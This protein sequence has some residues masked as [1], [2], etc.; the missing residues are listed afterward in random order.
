[1]PDAPELIL[2]RALAQLLDD[3]GLA[4]YQATGALPA[5]G[6]KTRPPMPTGLDEFTYLSSQPTTADG[7]RGNALYR[8]QFF[9]YRFGDA[10]SWGSE[11]F[12]RLDQ[13][14]YLPN[15]L[16]IS[17]TWETSRLHFDPDT[18]GR[19]AVACNYAFR[20]RRP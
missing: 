14:E 12:A 18:H 10:E 7:G 11:L 19:A 3:W 5:R 6:V 13:R 1:M 8:V 17:W 4:D 16:G 9:T 15:V 20:G 2:R